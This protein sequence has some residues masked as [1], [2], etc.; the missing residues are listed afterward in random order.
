MFS[1]LFQ[2]TYKKI[3]FEDLQIAIQNSSQHII[4]NTLPAHEQDCLIKNTLPYHLE[5]K[6]INELLNKYE[7]RTR[8]IFIYGRNS[9]DDTVEKKYKQLTGLGFSEVY[10][11]MG[12]MFEWM[13]L[14]DIYGKDEFPTSSRVLDILKFKPTSALRKNFLL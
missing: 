13:L 5:E 6:Y 4:I 9:N 11:Y 7:L 2:T 14:Q 12:G 8:Q 10:M 3:S 1:N